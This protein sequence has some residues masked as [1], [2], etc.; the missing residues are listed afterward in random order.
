MDIGRVD[1]IFP[2]TE[3]FFLVIRNIALKA[4]AAIY[5]ISAMGALAVT[6]NNPGSTVSGENPEPSP[7]FIMCWIALYGLT[8]ACIPFL[9][10][11]FHKGDFIVLSIGLYFFLG[12]LWSHIPDNTIKY[13]FSLIM[14]IIAA[15]VISRIV[16]KTEFPRF[17]AGIIFTVAC[18]SILLMVAGY[19][20]VLWIDP[21]SRTTIFQTPPLKGL[22][23]HKIPAGI[24][25]AL[26]FWLSIL[27]FKG[28]QRL[29]AAGV[30]IIFD[31]LTGSS[32]GLAL[33]PVAFLMISLAKLSRAGRLNTGAFFGVLG[34][35][36]SS[37][38]GFFYIFGADILALLDRDPTLT[39]R[40]LLWSWGIETALERPFLGWGFFGYF[41]SPE[42]TAAA[43]Q[44]SAF[45]NYDVPHF[46]N[47]YIQMLAEAGIIPAI[48]IFFVLFKTLGKWHANFVRYS[49]G[50]N[51]AF[52]TI[53]ALILFVA[54]FSLVF[55]R[56]N[57][58][59]TLLIC[60]VICYA[61]QPLVFA[62]PSPKSERLIDVRPRFQSAR[63]R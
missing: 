16:P 61:Y 62:R 60:I 23:F 4:Y 12:S 24:Y 51:L 22:F 32:I 15:I 7:M 3:N 47:S 19:P 8:F 54:G 53:M 46:H 14:N 18:I 63:P 30:C 27:V 38:I 43:K 28:W 49:G 35:V 42:A 48:I 39:G 31:G 25:A 41:G 2:L 5:I 10:W 37:G 17:L 57:D 55:I 13:S 21:H 33:I 1:A 40:T 20:N 44:I 9:K 26:G 45:R 34:L 50:H 36:F 6:I 59:S 56:Y 58:I 52:Y 29:V 11:R